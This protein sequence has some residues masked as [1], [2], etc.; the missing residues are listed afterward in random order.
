MHAR[1]FAPIL[2]RFTTVDPVRGDPRRPQSFN[3]FAYVQ[4]SPV[5]YADPKG[6]EI[7]LGTENASAG[8]LEKAERDCRVRRSIPDLK[9]KEHSFLG[10]FKWTS[11]SVGTTNAAALAASG[12]V[13]KALGEWIGSSKTLDF[14]WGRSEATNLGEGR[15]HGM[16]ASAQ[17]SQ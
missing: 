13:G 5:K 16:A 4:G 15:R 11:Y 1:S 10:L 9:A 12:N 8:D 14:K 17:R 3:L 2:A 7:A 6:L